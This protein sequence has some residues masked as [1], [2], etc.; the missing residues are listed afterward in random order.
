MQFSFLVKM[1]LHRKKK[2]VEKQVLVIFC[3]DIIG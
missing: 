2:H 1:Y 3:Q